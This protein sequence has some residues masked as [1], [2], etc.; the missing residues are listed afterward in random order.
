[1]PGEIENLLDRVDSAKRVQY[2]LFRYHCSRGRGGHCV[3]DV[4]RLGREVSQVFVVDAA[5]NGFE[6]ATMNGVEM[7]WSGGRKDSKLLE[8]CEIL[9]EL[10]DKQMNVTEFCAT[11]LTELRGIESLRQ[12]RMLP[13]RR[14]MDYG[15]VRF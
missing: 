12:R 8:L 5:R 9:A 2:R 13:M 11:M 10:F 4:K 3:K 6:E 14:N 15:L 1:M 7:F